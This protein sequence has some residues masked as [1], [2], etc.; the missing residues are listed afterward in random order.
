MIVVFASKVAVRDAL[1]D[2][3]LINLIKKKG[4]LVEVFLED[5]FHAFEG[6]ALDKQRSG[7]SGFEAIWGVAFSQ[8]H[9]AEAGSE[10]L[11]RVGFA[12]EDSPEELL[13]IGAVFFCPPD[14]PG[15]GP[16]QIALVAFGHVLGQSGKAALAVASL[17]AGD[18]FILEHNLHGRGR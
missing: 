11:F 7:A 5:G 9:D 10:A 15:W 1:V 13:C 3:V 17:M 14:N 6:I 4:L 18:S 12:L 16:L 2:F 8:A